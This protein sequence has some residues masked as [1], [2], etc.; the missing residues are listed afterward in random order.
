[1]KKILSFI[2]V[3]CVSLLAFSQSV[4]PS[5]IVSAG[6]ATTVGGVYVS[7]SVGETFVT[8]LSAGDIILTQGFQQPE[9]DN[10][11]DNDGFTDLEDCDDNNAAINPAA[12]EICDGIDNNCNVDIDEGL[13]NI[14]FAD[15][16]LDGFGDP[17]NSMEMCELTEGYSEDN[18]DCDDGNSLIFPGAS[19]LCNDF[20]DNCNDLVDDGLE[21]FTLYQDIDGDGYGSETTISTCE[22]LNGY[23]L[24][25]GDCDDA[26]AF[27]FPTAVEVCG[28]GV[29]DDCVAGDA[30][31]DIPGCTDPTA[32]NYNSEATVDDGSCVT[33]ILG[34]TDA[35]ALNYNPDATEDDGSCIPVVEG[36][37][38]ATAFNYNQEANTDD[39]SCIAVVE[40]CTDAT[41]FNYNQEANTDDGSC[42]P[43]V[44]GC[45]DVT[46]F[47]YNQEA[48]TDD[49]S[50]IAVVEGC[51]D[52]AAFNYNQEANTD[53]GSCIAVVEGCTDVTAFNYNQEANTDNGS[54]IPVVT[55]CIDSTACNFNELANTDDGSCILPQTE[56]CNGIDD[57]CN[58]Q[59]DE[60]L[61]VTDIV[62]V[63][64]TTALYP[65][66][67]GNALKPANLNNGS[68]SAIIEGDGPDLWFSLNAQYNTLRASL[69]AAFGDNEIRLYHVTNGCFELLETEHE[70]YTTSSLATGNQIL[71][72]DDLTVGENYYIAVHR[73]SGNSNASAKV[74]FNHFVGS[75]CD[76]YY[77]NNTGVYS[78]VCTSF[79]AQY[80]GN[81]TNYI[82]DI[83][84]ATQNSTNLN[85]T[86]WSYTTT[87]S[88]SVVPRLGTIF[89][90]NMTAS[91]KVYTLR[92]P[93]VYAIPDA[94]GNYTS[95]TA[96]ANTTCTVTLNAELPVA[97]R[98]SD[99]CPSTKTTTSSI[100]IDRTIC[101]ALRYEWEFTQQIPSV[102]PAVTVLGGLNTTVFFLSNVPG[103]GN[104]KTYNVRVRPIHVSGDVGA[105]GTSQCLKTGTSGM[106]LQSESENQSALTDG[107]NNLLPIPS[108]V[109]YPNPVSGQNFTIINH[110]ASSEEEM[111]LTI[112]DI[113]GKL[114]MKRQVF[115]NGQQLNVE[116]QGLSD[117][118][119]MVM[120]G[121]QRMR[122]VVTQ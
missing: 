88:N 54:C 12:D 81:A 25:A 51:T 32:N 52:A 106:M 68:N 108:M 40:G 72:S 98:A 99:R 74:C 43:V 59:V 77:S 110:S 16:D 78:S 8:T 109:L 7:W 17:L 119:Y 3:F 48:N 122:L 87:T 35:T 55:G 26:N 6:N 67:S 57:N 50:C 63:S 56:L 95:I 84:G 105:W 29:D 96:N 36:C 33:S 18:S 83:L 30:P 14:Y 41:A 121:D 46:A 60:G 85:I 9:V 80:K 115:F 102:Q 22:M 90:V 39:G 64:V 93:V 20:D 45:T 2:F 92:V 117:G 120:I 23:A 73:V 62:S 5:A 86:P 42:I 21:F 10:D 11:L 65:T 100:S 34:C 116:C 107:A 104:G 13:L 101:G 113:A 53:D 66:C 71:I 19:E 97:L 114:V 69:S 70:V 94:A 58:G 37:T 79:K 111:Q 103:M 76:H 47:N 44:E 15:L 89:P 118:V 38:D 24:N 82:F 4:S 91:A 112:N 61:Q 27:A 1:M 31:C 49:G 28:N 75:T